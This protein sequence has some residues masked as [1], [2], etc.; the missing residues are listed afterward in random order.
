M[1][2]KE[3]NLKQRRKTVRE[4][5]RERKDGRAAGGVE[6]MGKWMAR[7]RGSGNVEGVVR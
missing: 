6:K 1:A 7:R 2:G 3:N 4:G 5:E